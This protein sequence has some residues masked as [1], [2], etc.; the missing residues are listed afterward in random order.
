[1]SDIKERLSKAIEATKRNFQT[2]RTGRANPEILSRVQVDYYGSYVPLKQVCSITVP[3]HSTLLLT[4]FDKGS[5]KPVEKAIQTS[6]L[7]FNPQV[8]GTSIYL[9]IPPLTEERRKD[10][11][12]TVKKQG[13]EGKV[14]IRNVRRDYLDHLKKDELTEDQL[15]KEHDQA[16]KE[17][18]Q[19]IREIDELIKHKEKEI[20]TI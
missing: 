17:T 10:L 9:R 19:A 15:K 8:D 14:A 1:M 13:E 18:D 4:V 2:I 3:D 6:D 16:Q 11:I 7:G 12:K 20:M 5:V